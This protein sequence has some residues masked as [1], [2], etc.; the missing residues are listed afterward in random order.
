[1]GTCK[2]PVRRIPADDCVVTVN[3]EKCRIHEGEWVEV[4]PV[5]TIGQTLE[6]SGIKLA[7]MNS[8]EQIRGAIET[9]CGQLAKRILGWNLTDVMGEPIPNPHGKPEVLQALTTEEL[10]WLV[11]QVQRGETPEARK[12]A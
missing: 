8:E 7:G 10:F 12:N 11:A 6:M 9:I 5:A 3:G 2:L 1:M 4:V